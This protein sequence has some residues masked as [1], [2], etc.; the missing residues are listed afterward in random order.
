MRDEKAIKILF[1][2]FWGAGGWKSGGASKEEYAYCKQAGLVFDL[3]QLTHNEI[4]KRG[5]KAR[6]A[7][8]LVEVVNAF[9]CSLSSHHLELRSALGSY[10]VLRHLPDHSHVDSKKRCSV[11]GEYNHPRDNQDLDPLSFERYK[12]GGV[13]HL[14]VL[15]A[16]FDLEQFKMLKP[17]QPSSHDIQLF[18]QLLK[19]IEAA[20]LG[21]SSAKLQSFLPKELKS[22]KSE[23]DILIG[24]L[25][26]CGVLGTKAHPGF[27]TMFV[28]DSR[29]DLPDRRFVDMHYPACWWTRA[30]GINKESVKAVFGHAL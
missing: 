12:W 20:P 28:Q 19:A 29:R 18:K 24:I 22:N 4:V 2:Q 9:L 3:I 8:G 10:M 26:L 27:R 15:Y 11:C 25:G 16:G 23:R 14:Q 30:D 5:I 1:K 17:L 13:R 6:D 21:T 7:V